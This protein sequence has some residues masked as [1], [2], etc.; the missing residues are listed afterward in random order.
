MLKPV[1][2]GM[3]IVAYFI[4]GHEETQMNQV[5]YFRF[6]SVFLASKESYYLELITHYGFTYLLCDAL[7]SHSEEAILKIADLKVEL[8]LE[9]G[10]M[11]KD[12]VCIR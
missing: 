8:L 7:N 12:M 2:G 4:T 9:V 5:C 1:L 11:R 3:A 10:Y 6:F